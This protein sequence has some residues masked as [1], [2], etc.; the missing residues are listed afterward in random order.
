[1]LFNAGSGRRQ[2]RRHLVRGKLGRYCSGHRL[3]SPDEAALPRGIT[4]RWR[5]ASLCGIPVAS[6]WFRPP[7]SGM[8]RC[9]VTPFEGSEWSP[10]ASSRHSAESR[11][12]ICRPRFGGR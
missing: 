6:P 3:R 11:V 5:A 2:A 12:A 10:E 1:M 4:P 8:V 9:Q 7:Q